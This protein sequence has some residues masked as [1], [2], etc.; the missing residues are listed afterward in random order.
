MH[1]R[2]LASRLRLQGVAHAPPRPRRAGR[3]GLRGLVRRRTRHRRRLSAVPPRREL[4]AVPRLA[5][6][7]RELGRRRGGRG[8]GRALAGRREV[9]SRLSPLAAPAARAGPRRRR[10]AGPRGRA[11]RHGPP[12][13]P[14]RAGLADHGLDVGVHV[15]SALGGREHLHRRADRLRRGAPRP[16][17]RLAPA[18][19]PRPPQLG[20]RQRDQRPRRLHE[21]EG[22]A[23]RDR[24]LDAAHLPRV[25]GGRPG[26]PRHERRRHR[27]RP[28]VQHSSD[29]AL[30]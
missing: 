8:H 22:N 30:L 3:P 2:P 24:R 19:P 5:H 27:L 12:P 29:R 23:G 21:A 9:R 6:D 7:A 25:Q 28:A 4:R 10:E 26:D 17:R 20:L 11:S 16:R 13:R 15:P 14:P 18:R 1:P